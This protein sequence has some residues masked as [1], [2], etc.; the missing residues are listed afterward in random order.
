MK[1]KTSIKFVPI[2]LSGLLSSNFACG[3]VVDKQDEENINKYENNS[4]YE[5]AQEDIELENVSFE[6]IDVTFSQV[7]ELEEIEYSYIVKALINTKIYSYSNNKYEKIGMLIKGETLNYIEK[8]NEWIKVEYDGNTAFV[9]EEDIEII[10]YC[11]IY[12][13]E[14][15]P[16]ACT[17]EDILDL[18]EEDNIVVATAKVN[19]RAE[20]NTSSEKLDTLKVGDSL[21]LI[22]VFDEWC[23]VNYYGRS[24]YVYKDYIKISKEYY[25]KYEMSDMVYMTS[26]TPL[27]DIN[28]NENILS[29]PKREV[30]EVYAQNDD[31]YII[32]YNEKFGFVSKKY[33]YSLGDKYVIIDISSQNLKVYVDDK[34]VIDTPI[35]TGKDSSPTYCGLFDVRTKERNVYWPEFKVKVKY[36]L[37]F[38]RGEGMHDA[39]WRKKFGG[40]IFHEDGSHGCVN[41]PPNVMPSVYENVDVGTPVLVKK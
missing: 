38:N 41:I 6:N 8:N 10:E 5:L 20:A 34:L 29:I 25:P 35:V 28:T 32:K 15:I 31:Y 4:S 37:P 27:I 2:V 23:E 3:K 33:A 40:N 9:K 13:K 21:P 17:Q 7:D 26:A 18:F 24:A 39:K 12:Y 11:G 1:I 36:W 16:I 19:V 14:N 22:N 30:A